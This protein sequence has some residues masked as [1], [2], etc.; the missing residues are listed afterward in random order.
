MVLIV[1]SE[2]GMFVDECSGLQYSEHISTLVRAEYI[3]PKG[4]FWK[5]VNQQDLKYIWARTQDWMSIA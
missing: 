1:S 3:K 2:N 4:W 5:V